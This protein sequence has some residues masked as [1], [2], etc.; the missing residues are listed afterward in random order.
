MCN[1]RAPP[2]HTET[3]SSTIHGLIYILVPCAE[4][5]AQ[6]AKP[7]AQES[8]GKRH[9]PDK[10]PELHHPEADKETSSIQARPELDYIQEG[11]WEGLHADRVTEKCFQHSVAPWPS[12]RYAR[13][14]WVLLSVATHS[15]VCLHISNI[16]AYR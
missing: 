2:E 13:C 8:S 5:C 7:C 14:H 9:H 16:L 3:R 10:Q 15:L 1:E 6:C 12:C 4:A 11:C